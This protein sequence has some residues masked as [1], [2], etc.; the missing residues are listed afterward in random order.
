MGSEGEAEMTTAI[1]FYWI[2]SGIAVGSLSKNN[3]V[4]NDVV[5]LIFGG[6]LVPAK[7]IA[8]VIR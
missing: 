7:L 5:C 6:F 3:D 2:V 1:I 8:K 4:I